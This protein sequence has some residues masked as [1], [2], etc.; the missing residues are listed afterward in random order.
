MSKRAEEQRAKVFGVF[1]RNLEFVK[2]NLHQFEAEIRIEP[3]VPNSYVCPLCFGLFEKK[4]LFQTDPNPLTVEHVPPQKLG[5][6]PL[7]LTCKN[8]N[9]TAG[10]LLDAPLLSIMEVEDF[11]NFLPNSMA[12]VTFS[13]DGREMNGT[14]SIDDSAKWVIELSSKI[15]N[16]KH[17]EYFLNKMKRPRY[18]VM[19]YEDLMNYKP[20]SDSVKLNFR[21]TVEKEHLL[22]RA[23]VA[24]LRIAYLLAFGTFGHGFLIHPGLYAI[25]EQF[26]KPEEEILRK[27]FWLRYDFPDNYLGINIIRAPKQMLGFLVVFKLKTKSQS[28]NFG[29]VLPG[30][31]EPGLKV[32]DFLNDRLCQGDGTNFCR[33]EVQSIPRINFLTEEK[34]ALILHD[35]W[36]RYALLE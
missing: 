31:S 17:A 36:E 30:P 5:G 35:F 27:V 15:S 32:Y 16:P 3:D 26:K 29:I 10:H 2:R 7:V 9:S 12:R 28:R 25:R 23:E 13:K 33:I 22:R 1:S 20:G 8:C 14:I 24:L 19:S 6:T 21:M 11:K 34:H 18:E 4:A